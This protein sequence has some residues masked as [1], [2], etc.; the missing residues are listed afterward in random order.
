MTAARLQVYGTQVYKT[1]CPSKKRTVARSK[2]P[3][4]T[5]LFVQFVKF[6]LLFNHRPPKR[7]PS[8]VSR[9]PKRRHTDTAYCYPSSPTG[10]A[11]ARRCCPRAPPRQRPG[12]CFRCPSWRS[13]CSSQMRPACRRKAVSKLLHSDG[14][15][16]DAVRAHAGE[17]AAVPWKRRQTSD[18]ISGKGSTPRS[19]SVDSNAWIGKRRAQIPR[20]GNP[21]KASD[22]RD[23]CV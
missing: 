21:N 12:R 17:A 13:A 15:S 22:K 16:D 6:L 1:P 5:H 23:D 19:P 14:S 20:V 3:C 11:S 10:S 7:P 4:N 8:Q 9:R 2:P 18:A